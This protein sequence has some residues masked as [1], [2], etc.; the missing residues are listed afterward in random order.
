MIF[1]AAIAALVTAFAW[2]KSTIFSVN[3]ICWT[4]IYAQPNLETMKQDRP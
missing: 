2:D 4:T 3:E 1:S